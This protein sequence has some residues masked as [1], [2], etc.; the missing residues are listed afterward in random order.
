MATKCVAGV[1]IYALKI[2]DTPP[3]MC[4]SGDVRTCELGGSSGS[5]GSGG[6][7]IETCAKINGGA[8]GGCNWGGC[9][10]L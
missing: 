8:G 3:N 6:L 5:G 7:G 4:I 9:G 1:C 10:P 2:S